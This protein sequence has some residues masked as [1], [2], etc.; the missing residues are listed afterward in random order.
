MQEERG[1][2]DLVVSLQARLYRALAAAHWD[3]ARRMSQPIITSAL[4]TQTYDAGYGFN[5]LI[6]IIAAALLVIGCLVSSAAVFPLM[7]PVLFWYLS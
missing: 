4:Q 7:P 3:A 1:T 5:Y 6:Q 2:Q